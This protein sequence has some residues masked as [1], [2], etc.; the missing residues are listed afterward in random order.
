MDILQTIFGH[1]FVVLTLTVTLIGLLFWVASL[2]S[3]L[4]H[5]HLL[6]H[7]LGQDAGGANLEQGMRAIYGRLE[8]L[9]LH[10]NEIQAAE[11]ELRA[12]V[13]TSVRR[14]AIKRFNPFEDTGGDQSFALAMLNEEGSGVVVSSLHAREGTRVYAKPIVKG[15]AKYQ[16]TDEEKD[17]L[18]QAFGG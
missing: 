18:Q 4:N 9:G 12:L 10:L 16:L 11:R 1:W 17:V 14:V 5:T 2:Q 8:Q 6:M 13:M 7:Q 15:K 3:K